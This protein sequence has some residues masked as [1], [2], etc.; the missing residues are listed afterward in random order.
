[1]SWTVIK[2]LALRSVYQP[3]P[4]IAFQ[5]LKLD[6][7]SKRILLMSRAAVWY[8]SCSLDISADT[9]V[10]GTPSLT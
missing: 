2:G 8:I 3:K 7:A 1:M 9:L 10:F 5:L 4:P 6:V